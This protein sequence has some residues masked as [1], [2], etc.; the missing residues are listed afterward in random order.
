MRTLSGA[1]LVMALGAG[2]IGCSDG[3]SGGPVVPPPPVARFV[4]CADGV[5]VEDNVT[6]LLW[7]RKTTTGDVHDVTNTYTWSSTGTLADGTAFAEFLVGL[8]GATFAGHTDWR[9]PSISEL[10][11]ILVGPGVE[12]VADTDPAD[13]NSGLNGTGQATTCAA[14]PCID[15]DFAAIGGPTASPLYW[16]ES[17]AASNPPLAWLANFDNGGADFIILRSKTSAGLVRAVR[18]GSCSS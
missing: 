2:G 8:N 4:E 11:S 17:T 7:E 16:S 14:A 15:P 3:D 18:P 1:V 9:L 6:G 13:P 5:T 12:F 10:Q